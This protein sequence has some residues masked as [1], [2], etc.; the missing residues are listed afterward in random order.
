[1]GSF[2][3]QLIDN[4]AQETVHLEFKRAVLLNDRRRDEVC[5]AVSAM[6]NSD[7]GKLVFGLAEDKASNTF[8]LDE[9]VKD[10][11]R[12]IEWLDSITR[13]SISPRIEGVIVTAEVLAG[14]NYVCVEIPK[15]PSAPHQGP[16]KRFYKRSNNSS[17]PM[18]VYEIDDVRQRRLSGLPPIRIDLEVVSGVFAHLV[19]RNRSEIVCRDISLRVESDFPMSRFN[20]NMKGAISLGR[21]G[22]GQ[23]IDYNLGSIFEI[24]SANKEA[25]FDVTGT[26]SSEA[27][28]AAVRILPSRLQLDRQ[29]P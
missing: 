5:K 3:E 24:L 8:S 23:R 28:N 9:G 21:L 6:A 29:F 2:I 4:G 22:A 7:G 26:Y 12:T 20:R 17:Y 16:D 25:A 18:E 13:D 14:R 1:M 19:I 10:V 15:S 11:A 27:N